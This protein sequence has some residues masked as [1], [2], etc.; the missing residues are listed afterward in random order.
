MR[1]V[2]VR[3][4][5]APRSLTGRWNSYEDGNRRPPNK[6]KKIK[7]KQSAAGVGYALLTLYAS[8]TGHTL[9]AA[10]TMVQPPLA[11]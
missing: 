11:W 9:T 4:Q 8:K 1:T 7:P 2:E 3:S 10:Y 5:S 6:T